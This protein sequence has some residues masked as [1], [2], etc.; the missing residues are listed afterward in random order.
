[1]DPFVFGIAL[2]AIFTVGR[3]TR[4]LLLEA[5]RRKTRRELGGD[6]THGSRE[7]EGMRDAMDGVMGRLERLEEERDFYKDLLDAPRRG[8]EIGPP[9]T[10]EN[11][12]DTVGA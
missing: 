11:S 1:L 12:S 7:F 3:T 4:A 2:A 9:D 10:E 8:R 5:S 6:S